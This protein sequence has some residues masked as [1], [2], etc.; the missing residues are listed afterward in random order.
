[1]VD[2][3]KTVQELAIEIG[4]KL[5]TK[6]PHQ[7]SLQV[8]SEEN[9]N[10]WLKPQ[11][12]LPEQG[13]DTLGQTLLYRKKYFLHEYS[14]ADLV[15]NEQLTKALCEALDATIASLVCRPEAAVQLAAL[16]CQVRFGD[17]N[18]AS[19]SEFVLEK[20]AMIVLTALT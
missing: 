16:Q 3:S 8:K 13:I 11:E 10:V 2:E 6:N 12:T 20:Y 19:E 14:S 17:C 15:D 7:F 9:G 5:Q 1:M 18:V 4:Q